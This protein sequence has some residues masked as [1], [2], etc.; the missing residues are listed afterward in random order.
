MEGLGV[1]RG[2]R[3]EFDDF[4][5]RREGKGE[6]GEDLKRWA[7]IL[8]EQARIAQGLSLNHPDDFVKVEASYPYVR[9]VVK[10]REWYGIAA[11]KG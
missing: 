10:R 5:F 1:K 3:L 7:H 2:G 9:A 11:S 6:K 4:A 8:Y